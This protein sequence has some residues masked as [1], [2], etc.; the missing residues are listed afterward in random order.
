MLLNDARWQLK[1]KLADTHD[2]A[3]IVAYSSVPADFSERLLSTRVDQAYFQFE[4]AVLTLERVT[5]QFLEAEKPSRG[6]PRRQPT[7]PNARRAQETENGHCGPF[8]WRDTGS[9]SCLTRCL[10]RKQWNEHKCID[11]WLWLTSGK[12]EFTGPI[13][14]K[15][16]RLLPTE[17]G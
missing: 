2:W 5:K 8:K 11:I 4:N 10:R 13:R 15:I 3:S 9:S 7:L 16:R 1:A 6:R 14:T 17:L 12:H